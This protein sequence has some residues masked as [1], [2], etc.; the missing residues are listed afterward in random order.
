MAQE[1]SPSQQSTFLQS[2]SLPQSD[3]G[4]PALPFSMFSGLPSIDKIPVEKTECEECMTTAPRIF[5]MGFSAVVCPECKRVFV[6]E[7]K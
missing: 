6:D 3:N 1:L 5:V 7:P 4:V 2:L